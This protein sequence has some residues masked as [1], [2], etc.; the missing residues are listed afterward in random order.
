MRFST[1]IKLIVGLIFLLLIVFFVFENN[2]PV[3]IWIPFFKGRHINLI[4]IIVAFYL[5]GISN[6]LWMVALIGAERRKRMK[7]AEI[8]ESEQSLFEDEA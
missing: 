3:Q 7:L 8:P 1:V 5:I 6:A 4:Y 2:D